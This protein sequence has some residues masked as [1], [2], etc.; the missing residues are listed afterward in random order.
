VVAPFEFP[1]PGSFHAGVKH[2]LLMKRIKKCAAS[3]FNQRTPN[4][5]S[6]YLPFNGLVWGAGLYADSTL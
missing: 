4:Q 2:R 6:C 1:E 3:K 5:I